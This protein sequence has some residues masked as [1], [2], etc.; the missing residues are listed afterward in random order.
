MPT[1]LG[2]VRVELLFT[3]DAIIA[4]IPDETPDTDSLISVIRRWLDLDADIVRIKCERP[5]ARLAGRRTVATTAS[6]SSG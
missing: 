1:P 6:N 3:E 4:N 2:H 5:P